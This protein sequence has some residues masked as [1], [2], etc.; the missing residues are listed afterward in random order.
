[1]DAALA[2]TYVRRM[3]REDLT[4]DLSYERLGDTSFAHVASRPI[5]RL[6]RG[7]QR[8]HVEIVLLDGDHSIDVSVQ[9]AAV[10]DLV[11]GHARRL[12][13]DPN[14]WRATLWR[15]MR[16]D[17]ERWR[18]W[19]STPRGDLSRLLGGLGHPMLAAAYDAGAAAVTEIP[20]WASP[21]FARPNAAGAAV[22]L[23]GTRCA[24]RTVMRAFAAWLTRPRLSWWHLGAAVVAATAVEPD[25]AARWL[26]TDAEASSGGPPSV[27]KV[28]A[29]VAGLALLD[30][31]RARRLLHDARRAPDGAEA[32][33]LLAVLASLLD[34][35][36]DLRWP[37]PARLS[38]L[39]AACLRAASLDPAPPPPPR[40]APV[41]IEAPAARAH[42]AGAAPV[43]GG[44]S[45][46]ATHPDWTTARRAPSVRGPAPRHDVEFSP[47]SMAIHVAGMTAHDDIELVAPRTPSE[48][49]AWG[50]LLRNCLADFAPAVAAGV[51]AVFGIRVSGALAGAVEVRHGRI[52]Q[53]LGPSNRPLPPR[54]VVAVAHQVERALA[55]S[56]LH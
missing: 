25:D 10:V 24:T 26:A 1:M 34:V 19:S 2:H 11:N 14:A 49:A 55:A 37:P 41:A 28:R 51:T 47:S 21:G 20:K 35:E 48:L 38:D 23:F 44:A 4:E 6:R 27:E 50:Q 56:R 8:A 36:R 15:A 39:E 29:A 12:G 33:R 13:R 46:A 5:L 7:D 32:R 3:E 18:M 42:P 53:L 40:P 17:A 52:I 9:P 43:A 54:V 22:E 30:R 16:D 31:D 45:T